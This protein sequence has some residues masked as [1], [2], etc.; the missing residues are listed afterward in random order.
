MKKTASLHNIKNVLKR[1]LIVTALVSITTLIIMA[2][3]GHLTVQKLGQVNETV[4]EQA[5]PL[6]ESTLEFEVN[7]KGIV[8]GASKY[9]HRPS[10]HYLERIEDSYDDIQQVLPEIVKLKQEG[11]PAEV[12]E[13]LRSLAGIYNTG[14]K[15]VQLTDELVTIE[16]DADTLL[17]KLDQLQVPLV[18]P[19]GDINEEHVDMVK[20]VNLLKTILIRI[21]GYHSGRALANMDLA[22]I[23]DSLELDQNDTDTEED[24]T[25]LSK[26]IIKH[27]QLLRDI[28]LKRDNELKKL[29]ELR[30]HTDYLL[31]DVLQPD[32]KQK[33]INMQQQAKD[34]IAA[35]S[36]YFLLLA[37]LGISVLLIFTLIIVREFIKILD[38]FFMVMEH[39]RQGDFS[40]RLEKIPN[41]TIANDV[42]NSLNYTLEKLQALTVAQPYTD[43]LW[44]S[45]SGGLLMIDPNGKILRA[46][47][48]MQKLVDVNNNSLK[49]KR[50]VDYFPSVN[51]QAKGLE[52]IRTELNSGNS[53]IIPV[54]LS[55]KPVYGGQDQ[56][57]LQGYFCSITDL[58]H[59][60]ETNQ[61]L[62]EQAEGLRAVLDTVTDAIVVIDNE[63]QIIFSNA[64]TEQIFGYREEHILLEHLNLILPE[65]TY[66]IPDEASAS[67]ASI[68]QGRDRHGNSLQLKVSVGALIW[69]GKRALVLAI[70]TCAESK[71]GEIRSFPG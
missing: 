7:I 69:Q 50:L 67:E 31:D 44:K 36:N 8:L 35:N 61:Q 23:H 12:D 27:Y 55:I 64:R 63:S 11:H 28:G 32:A 46:N 5:L 65:W 45:T 71:K 54:I 6:F 70:Q 30:N 60:I 16:E 37:G 40:V 21:Q 25:I 48:A 18:S 62:F 68:T 4:S 2:V 56:T 26:E 19:E 3:L 57:V 49:E 14:L 33:V 17:D 39:L 1:R 52:E 58:R 47:D 15:I 43:I 41:G 34:N 29:F 13:L 10:L 22:L 51:L 66:Q 42:R 38:R 24:I 20:Q 53:K 59:D 9:A